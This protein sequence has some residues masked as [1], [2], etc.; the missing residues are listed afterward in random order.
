ML[1]D[2]RFLTRQ[3]VTIAAVSGEV[4]MSNA[5]A[6][7]EAVTE[8]VPNDAA[9]AVLDLSAVDYMDSAGIHLIYRLRENLRARG[10]L[11]RLVIPVGSPV[12]DSLRLAG[13]LGGID[14]GQTVE[15]ALGSLGPQP[16]I[17]P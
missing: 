2:V 16:A 8:Q 15:D 6:I 9:G 12:S 7:G 17:E 11:L 10:L 3:A 13:V 1:G 5:Q 4:D 14:V